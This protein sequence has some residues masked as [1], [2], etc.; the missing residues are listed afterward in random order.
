[1]SDIFA[2]EN[3][4]ITGTFEEKAAF[5]L[6]QVRKTFYL[7]KKVY[8]ESRKGGMQNTAL[9]LAYGPA[10][11]ESAAL[12][13]ESF[14]RGY[15]ANALLDEDGN[16]TDPKYPIDKMVNAELRRKRAHVILSVGGYFTRLLEMMGD[17]KV[18]WTTTE[19]FGNLMPYVNTYAH[20]LYVELS[21]VIPGRKV[22]ARTPAALVDFIS[23]MSVKYN[24]SAVQANM[25]NEMLVQ[26]LRDEL[27]EFLLQDIPYINHRAVATIEEKNPLIPPKKKD[28]EE[29]P[30]LH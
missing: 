10:A 20:E 16:T 14:F 24:N 29:P 17:E 30:I 23:F 26:R 9:H 19:I 11:A 6:E 3:Y 21:T 22:P 4:P 7:Q 15:L 13:A 28:K 1:M 25:S 5:G 18:M 12:Q 27:I 2:D 8:L